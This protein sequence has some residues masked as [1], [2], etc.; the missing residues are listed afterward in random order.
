MVLANTG[1]GTRAAAP[2]AAAALLA[3]G[4][5]SATHAL[6]HSSTPHHHHPT[7]PPATATA[8]PVAPDPTL[9]PLATKAT[10]RHQTRQ[11][12]A[13]GQ[14]YPF[15]PGRIVPIPRPAKRQPRG[16]HAPGGFAYLGGVPTKPPPPAPAPRQTGIPGGGGEFSP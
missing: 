14:V 7:T 2:L 9:P 8:T 15:G 10:H 12:P 4:A 3:A 1:T 11:Q 16:Q 6:T 5:I 13:P